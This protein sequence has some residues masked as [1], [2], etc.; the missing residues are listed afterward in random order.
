VKVWDV[1]HISSLQS[2]QALMTMVTGYDHFCNSSAI[3]IGKE[4]YCTTFAFFLTLFFS[5]Y[6]AFRFGTAGNTRN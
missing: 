1:N 6:A 3:E 5:F 4:C 2:P